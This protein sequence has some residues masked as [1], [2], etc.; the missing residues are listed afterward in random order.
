MLRNITN[1]IGYKNVGLLGVSL[2]LIFQILKLKNLL[3][4]TLN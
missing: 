3:I 2:R 4:F 1:I